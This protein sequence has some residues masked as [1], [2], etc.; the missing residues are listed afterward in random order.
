MKKSYASHGQDLILR[1]LMES[2][3]HGNFLDIGAYHPIVDSNSYL[4]YEL[5][6]RGIAIEPNSNFQEEWS[7]LRPRDIFINKAFALE[8]FATYYVHPTL[9][10]LNST[11]AMPIYSKG[12]ECSSEE[13]EVRQIAGISGAEVARINSFYDFLSLDVEGHEEII[14]HNLLNSG[15]RFDL[16]IIEC[17]KL[18]MM[19]DLNTNSI[20]RLCERFELR[21]ISKLPHDLIFVRMGGKYDKRF[22]RNMLSHIS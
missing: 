4:F 14:L 1:W 9:P 6:W 11:S 10:T 22:P 16:A 2:T 3:T 12:F 19:S 7:S 20:I 13:I 17:N 8:E 18:N 21:P 5:G 15:V